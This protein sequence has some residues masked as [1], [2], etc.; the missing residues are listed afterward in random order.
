MVQAEIVYFQTSFCS[1]YI[2]PV[3]ISTF[4]LTIIII[5]LFAPYLLL[6]MKKFK[7]IAIDPIAVITGTASSKPCLWP[8]TDTECQIWAQIL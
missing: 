1:P 2:I 6:K 7:N 4:H 5:T 3:S 8:I